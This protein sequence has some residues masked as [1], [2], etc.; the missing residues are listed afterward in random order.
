[1]VG[2]GRVELP[3]NGLGIGQLFLN[4]YVFSVFSSVDFVLFWAYSGA[5]HATDLATLSEAGL[6]YQY[7]YHMIARY[8]RAAREARFE[9]CFSPPI[10]FTYSWCAGRFRVV[11]FSLR[12]TSS[13]CAISGLSHR[14][15]KALQAIP[16]LLEKVHGLPER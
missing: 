16:P 9:I 4:L 2:L 5:E 1:M 8:P 3:T 7:Q 10:L 13:L 6:H 15:Q 11:S 12:V 14:E